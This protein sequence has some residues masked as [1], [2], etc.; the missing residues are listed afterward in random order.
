MIKAFI[1]DLDGT[2][3][4]SMSVWD[5]FGFEYLSFKD[6]KNIPENLW[7]ILKTMSLLEAAEYFISDW[8]IKLSPEQICD[9]INGLIEKKYKYEV[10]PKNG[11]MEF[12]EKYKHKKMCIATATDK[13]LVEYAIK[14]LEMEKYFDFV[15]TSTEIGSSKQ[16]PDIFIKAAEKL[17]VKI[18]EAVV[19]EDALHAIRSAKSAGFY[20]VGVYEKCFENEKNE[21]INTADEYVYNLNDCEIQCYAFPNRP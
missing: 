21:I 3:L 15:I 1:F 5:N 10:V 13:H 7:E 6:I 16:S 4:D 8:G 12:L 9:E 14:R 20:T 2:L 19:F 18:S 11:V 17:G